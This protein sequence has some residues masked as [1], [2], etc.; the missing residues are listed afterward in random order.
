MHDTTLTQWSNTLHTPFLLHKRI[1]SQFLLPCCPRDHV[2]CWELNQTSIS[3]SR[4]Q[5]KGIFKIPFHCITFFT[6]NAF[7]RTPLTC[8][9]EKCTLLVSL[10]ATRTPLSPSL[11]SYTWI[12][13]HWCAS[14]H[15]THALQHF[16][17]NRPL[18]PISAKFPSFNRTN[19][20]SLPNISLFCSFS[21]TLIFLGSAPGLIFISYFWTWAC[22]SLFKLAN[23]GVIQFLP[24][25]VSYTTKVAKRLQCIQL[26]LS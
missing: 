15:R 19:S 2:K 18:A 4:K 16:L 9:M 12:D 1:L 3:L 21:S 14:H 10:Q 7:F 8:T 23:S 13:T 24:S 5:F 26:A 22:A 17:Y 20:E 25:K 6:Q 11:L